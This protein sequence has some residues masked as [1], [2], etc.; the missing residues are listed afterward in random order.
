MAAYPQFMYFPSIAMPSKGKELLTIFTANEAALDTTK[1]DPI[2]TKAA[3]LKLIADELTKLGMNPKVNVKRIALYGPQLI[4]RY[5]YQVDLEVPDYSL[6]IATDDPQQMIHRDLMQIAFL[7]GSLEEEPSLVALA[8]PMRTMPSGT[9]RGDYQIALTLLDT[10]VA[11]S[12]FSL[13][14]KLLVIGY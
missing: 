10:L 14:S 6:I 5:E 3:L 13:T 11:Y 7:Q 2:I 4:P 8:I 1:H 12:R 9:P